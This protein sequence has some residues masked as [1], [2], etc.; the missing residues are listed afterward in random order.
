MYEMSICASAPSFEGEL[1]ER[2]VHPTIELVRGVADR[3]DDLEAELGMQLKAG[4]V[5][6]G[7]SGHERAVAQ[8]A[9]LLYELRQQ[10]STDPSPLVDRIY[11]NEILHDVEAAL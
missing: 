5:V 11:V 6:G 9:L 10:C 8:A 7:D 4:A 2:D 3:A 1:D